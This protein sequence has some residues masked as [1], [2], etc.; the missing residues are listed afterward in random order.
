M[1]SPSEVKVSSEVRMASGIEIGHDKSHA[2][3]AQENQNHQGG[4]K[5]GDDGF[6][7][8]SLDGVPHEQ[9]LIG[10]GVNF[11]GRQEARLGCAATPRGPGKRYRGLRPCRS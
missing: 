3:A 1:V 2:P 9:G 10:N 5:G 4:Q 6:A 7:E 8:H 11:Q